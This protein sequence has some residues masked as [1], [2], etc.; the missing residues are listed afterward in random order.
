MEVV[1]Y[2]K[3]GCGYCVKAKSLCEAKGI[4]YQYKQV[5]SDISKELLEEMVG[6]PI[7]TVPQIFIHEDGFYTYVGGFTELKEKLN[8]K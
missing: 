4:T 5:G 6:K 8:D 7:K 1:I 3:P 2:G